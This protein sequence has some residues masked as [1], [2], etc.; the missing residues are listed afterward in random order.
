MELLSEGMSC[1]WIQCMRSPTQS[2]NQHPLNP[3]YVKRNV[4][5]AETEMFKTGMV[6]VYIMEL[7]VYAEVS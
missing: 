4:S 7:R 1:V 3:V 6:S 5:P 2:F